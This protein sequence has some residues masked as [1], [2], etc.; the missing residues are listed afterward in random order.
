MRQIERKE[1]DTLAWIKTFDEDAVFYDIG[2]NVGIFTVIA[3]ARGIRTFAFEPHAANFGVLTLNVAQNG[4]DERVDAFPLAI[5]DVDGPESF[6]VSYGF[7]G[8]S[9]HSV[10]EALDYD[11][12]P[13]SSPFRQATWSATLDHVIFDTG[14]PAPTHIKI[15]VD[16]FEHTII[17]G[18][19][20]T[21]A[22]PSLRS[23]MIEINID[24][25][26]HRRIADTLVSYGLT[27]DPAA[28]A[29]LD[30]R[31]ADPDLPNTG[32]LLFVRS[33]WIRGSPAASHPA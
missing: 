21:L 10:K 29:R 7:A 1:P 12:K 30:A 22:L 24:L 14:L 25:E 13:R 4:L 6:H 32:N 18:G 23:M 15:D 27:P 26:Q 17:A 9:G 19:I 5:S 33:S 2:A 20:R 16:G 28:E 11:L 8:T 31:V 3:G